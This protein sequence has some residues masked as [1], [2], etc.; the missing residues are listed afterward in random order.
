MPTIFISYRRDDSAQFCRPLFDELAKR[1]GKEQI[2]MD[3]DSFFPGVIFP[4]EIERYIKSSDVLLAVVGSQW[5]APNPANSA[6]RRIDNPGDFVHVEI[7]LAIRESIP[8][9]PI[10]LDGASFPELPEDIDA[11][12]SHNGVQISSD[13]SIQDNAEKIVH[14]IEV[15]SHVQ[16]RQREQE[17]QQR[18]LQLGQERQAELARIEQERQALLLRTEKNRQERVAAQQRKKRLNRRIL[19]GEL[20][21]L[22]IGGNIGVFASIVENIPNGVNPAWVVAVTAFLGAV[23]GGVM[24]GALKVPFFASL[25]AVLRVRQTMITAEDDLGCFGAFIGFMVGAM[26]VLL[27]FQYVLTSF[28]QTQIGLSEAALLAII[29]GIIGMRR[30]GY[31]GDAI[32]KLFSERIIPHIQAQ[33]K[34]FFRGIF[35]PKKP[36][37][38]QVAG[39]LIGI[40]LCA[41][42]VLVGALAGSFLG[43]YIGVAVEFS[44]RSFMDGYNGVKTDTNP[45]TVIGSHLGEYIGR[46]A[47]AVILGLMLLIVGTVEVID[48]LNHVMNRRAKVTTPTGSATTPSPSD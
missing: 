35:K 44:V 12:K 42:G 6:E 47:G 37:A 19:I 41:I 40:I 11:L 10:L 28:S 26:V 39:I 15:Q 21:G 18:L 23:M 1:F 7:A 29:V 20:I 43:H 30:G 46:I 25:R 4:K 31:A 9:I 17:E 14:A 32:G 33:T 48:G 45:S 3:L 34:R 2:I 27:I 13:A 36:T 8:I 22:A 16:E 5:A 24:G 38:R